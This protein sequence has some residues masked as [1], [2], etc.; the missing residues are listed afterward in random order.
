MSNFIYNSYCVVH[1]G[2][3]SIALT[4]AYRPEQDG[5]VP[6]APAAR[7]TGFSLAWPLVAVLA[8]L[9]AFASTGEGASVL[10]GMLLW[11]LALAG[12]ALSLSIVRRALVSTRQGLRA[13][14]RSRRQAA[15]DDRTWNQALKDARM[16]ADLSRAMSAQSHS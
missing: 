2:A 13:W 3:E 10:V 6:A 7:S 1:A 12:W 14:K 8:L 15:E 4:T 9:G 16:M 5:A 11:V